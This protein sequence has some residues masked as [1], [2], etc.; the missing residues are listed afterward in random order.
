MDTLYREFQI[1]PEVSKDWIQESLDHIFGKIWR[2]SIN[3]DEEEEEDI[4]YEMMKRFFVNWMNQHHPMKSKTEKNYSRLL[5]EYIQKKDKWIQLSRCIVFDEWMKRRVRRMKR[6]GEKMHFHLT[7]MEKGDIQERLDQIEETMND[8]DRNFMRDYSSK[9]QMDY[10]NELF[11][12]QVSK[13]KVEVK[14]PFDSFYVNPTSH[15]SDTYESF[16]QNDR[17]KKEDEMDYSILTQKREAVIERPDGITM[18]NFNEMFERQRTQDQMSH[19]T[20]LDAFFQV[21]PV[22]G[23]SSAFTSNRPMTKEEMD[24]TISQHLAASEVER[25]S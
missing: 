14:N 18:D 13:K 7:E 20:G 22:M 19:R 4:S 24:K 25:K 6:S 15:I 23:T 11:T 2:L 16:D 10:F 9:E 21:E 8:M 1:D 5:D 12:R 17:F 3:T